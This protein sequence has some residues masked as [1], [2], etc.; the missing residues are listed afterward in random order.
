MISGQSHF[1][2]YLLSCGGEGEEGREMRMT[3]N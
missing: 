2:R 3:E 1:E